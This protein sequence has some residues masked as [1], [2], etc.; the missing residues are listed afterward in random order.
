MVTSRRKPFYNWLLWYPLD[1]S[2]AEAV[3][4]LLRWD[5]LHKAPKTVAILVDASMHYQSWRSTM[6]HDS[7]MIVV[8][9]AAYAYRMNDAP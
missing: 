2:Y 6:L 1:V 3:I 7:S 8:N 4:N 9:Y 5:D